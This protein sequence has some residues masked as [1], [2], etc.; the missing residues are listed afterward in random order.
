MVPGTQ[1]PDSPAGPAGTTVFS[2][3]ASTGLSEVLEDSGFIALGRTPKDPRSS[4]GWSYEYGRNADATSYVLKA[5]LETANNVLKSDVDDY[6]PPG[7]S[8]GVFCGTAATD[9]EGF[10]C[11]SF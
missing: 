9:V 10:Y 7:N 4:A 3:D 8:T 2:W 1:C 11:V 6:F 5:Q